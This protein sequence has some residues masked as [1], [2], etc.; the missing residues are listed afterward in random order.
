MIK[1]VIRQNNHKDYF[2]NGQKQTQE[3]VS[4]FMFCGI[5]PTVFVRRSA[6]G[7][8]TSGSIWQRR[9]ALAFF[10]VFILMF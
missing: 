10:S 1:T 2:V 6:V 7:I 9:E 4:S 5:F 8:W 3:Q